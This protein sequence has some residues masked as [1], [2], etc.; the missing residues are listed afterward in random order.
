[1][2][3]R[4]CGGPVKAAEEQSRAVGSSEN[5]F[6]HNCGGITDWWAEV[7]PGCG[8]KLQ[9]GSMG[10]RSWL[11]TLFLC[12]FFGAIGIHRFYTGFVLVGLIQLL[13]LGGVGIWAMVDLIR[14]ILGS[15]RDSEGNPLS[16]R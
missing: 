16:R 7:C 4:H 5:R 6:C 3:C 14:I 2:Y 1:M 13:T 11:T 9:K 10:G 15:Y 8:A 12:I